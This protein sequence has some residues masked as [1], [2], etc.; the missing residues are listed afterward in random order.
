MGLFIQIFRFRQQKAAEKLFTALLCSALLCS[1]LLCS[2]L[3]SVYGCGAAMSRFFS[4][5]PLPFSRYAPIIS[6]IFR[7]YRGLREM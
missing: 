2:A 4:C 7:K 5:A 6:Q 3:L 1:A